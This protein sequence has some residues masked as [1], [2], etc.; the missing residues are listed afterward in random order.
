MVL[1]KRCRIGRVKPKRQLR[2][3][4]LTPTRELAAQVQESVVTYGKY[5]GLKSTVIFGGVGA[6]PQIK[7]SRVGVKINTRN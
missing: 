5:T 6:N 2:V 3:L 7:D 4:I 1:L